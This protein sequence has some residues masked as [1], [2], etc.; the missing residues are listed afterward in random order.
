M[1]TKKQYQ[2]AQRT[3]STCRKLS[4]KYSRAGN[5]AALDK[6]SDKAA[7]ALVVI[8]EYERQHKQ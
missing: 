1:I 4:A 5:Q 2:A 3:M 6:V 7:R 8:V